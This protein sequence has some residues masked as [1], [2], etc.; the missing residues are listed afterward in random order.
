AIG[1]KM[2]DNA[3]IKVE[4]IERF[5]EITNRKIDHNIILDRI[6]YWRN[7]FFRFNKGTRSTCNK[8]LHHNW[9]IN[10]A[11]VCSNVIFKSSN[12]LDRL[13]TKLIDQHHVIG[14]PDNLRTV[15]GAKKVHKKTSTRLIGVNKQATIKHWFKKNS[16]KMYNKSGC[17][18]RI[19][20][21]INTPK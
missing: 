4:N 14:Y 8:L 3:F 13:Y 7:V 15:F 18:L 20:T 6:Y 12:F 2:K 11:E 1:Y 19:E 21:T 5:K 9:F 17:L 10:Q 16:I